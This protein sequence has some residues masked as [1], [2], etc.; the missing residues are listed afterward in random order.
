MK[1]PLRQRLQRAVAVLLLSTAASLV[2][3]AQG[4]D[5][6]ARVNRIESQTLVELLTR[7]DRLQDEM[8]QMRG[9]LEEQAHDIEGMQQRQ[10][11]M[12][13]ELD[14]RLRKLEQSGATA[15]P[16]A[17]GDAGAA[18][19][20][21][22]DENA[23]AP[24]DTGTDAGTA[25]GADNEQGSYQRA[26]DLLKNA[27]YPKAIQGF[28]AFLSRYPDSSLANNAQYWLGEANYV[29][30][31]YKTAL[32]EFRK[33]IDVYPH[34][35]KIPDAMLKIGFIHYAQGNWDKARGT[36]TQVKARYP[37]SSAARL[38]DERLRK[39]KQEGH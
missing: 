24:T 30:R 32:I 27:Q 16:P 14:N 28:H 11:D 12:Y 13:M 39:M 10:K 36:L 33:V 18:P 23:P 29:L 26:F 15:A 9:H 4:E 19:P 34:S 38:A 1:L 22:S 8:Q 3:A 37:G 6:E 17:N 21:A 35:S 7:I 31:D 5:L 2:S 20:A 25:A